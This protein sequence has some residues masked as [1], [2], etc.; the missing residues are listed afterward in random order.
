MKKALSR[1]LTVCMLF[2]L[3]LPSCAAETKNEENTVPSE[4]NTVSADIDTA[5]SNRADAAE[6]RDADTVIELT[7]GEAV[8][9]V[10]G[11]EKP[12]DEQGTAPV[13]VQNRTLLP[14]RSVVEE[15]GGSVEWNGETREVTLRV[16]GDTVRL[17][18][19]S[20]TAYRNDEEK[21][22]D[23]APTVLNNRT[24]LPI[25]FIAE[26][27]R[28]EVAYDE[29]TKTVSIKKTVSQ[30][31][32][33]PTDEKKSLVVYFSATG[34][35]KAFAEKIAKVSGA[36]LWEIVPDEPYTSEDLDYS[37]D[38]CR[39]NLEQHDDSAR[40]KI[41]GTVENMDSYDTIFLGYPI[42]WGTMPKIILTFVESYDLSG[43]TILP[44]C[45]SG[46]SGISASVSTLSALVKDAEVKEGLRGSASTS[47][48]TI[49]KWLDSVGYSARGTQA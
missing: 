20:T 23:V 40:P 36:D 5:P 47:D 49:E 26:S 38:D 35:T 15:L 8:M 6:N 39:A 28:F 21:T 41:D 22:L 25:R 13:I 29:A 3:F 44:F 12:I 45:T 2:T 46:G 34:N 33:D 10:N 14:V 37:H 9:R 16:G 30:T 4:T 24:M 43:K 7:V 32:S 11:A 31:P 48:E 27:F 19:N 17:T 1:L 18:I 42:W